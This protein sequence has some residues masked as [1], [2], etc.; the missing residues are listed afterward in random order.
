M[1]VL[2]LPWP[3][4]LGLLVTTLLV[5]A[6][7]LAPLVLDSRR[8]P[9]RSEQAVR[10]NRHATLA[11]VVGVTLMVL[12]LLVLANVPL[13]NVTGETQRDGRLIAVLP[14]LGGL[15]LVLAQAVGQVTWPRPTGTLREA[16]LVRRRVADVA[17]RPQ[18]LLLVAW[19]VLTLAT[20]VVTVLAASGPRTLSGLRDGLPADVGPYPGWY[21]AVPVTVA[22]LAL[23]AATEATLR[24][25]TLRPAVA[26]VAP[27][28]DLHLRR[29]SARHL[30]AGVQLA[31]GAQLVVVLTLAG[32][33]HLALGN[34]LTGGTLVVAAVL[35]TLVSLAAV[36]LPRGPR[37]PSDARTPAAVTA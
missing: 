33:A 1:S 2:G 26:A 18:R 11:S 22:V 7:A 27:A 31:L 21:Y 36:W 10:A 24:L 14:A 29:R 32:W 6:V 30:L 34:R 5:F 17:P 37:R 3:A 13:R 15:C 4:G 25:I 35:V 8:T 16:E 12:V 28:W 19:P 9:A 23:V 20:L